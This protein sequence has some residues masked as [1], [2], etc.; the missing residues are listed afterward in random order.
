MKWPEE[1]VLVRHD[2]SRFNVLKEIKAAD[3]LYQE[4][5]I[6][7]ESDPDSEET[8]K[9]ARMV[10]KVFSLGVSD[11]ET[12]LLHEESPLAETVGRKLRI[13][14]GKSVPDIIFVSP[15]K[16]TRFTLAGLIRGWPELNDVKIFE[17]ERIREQEHGI[18]TLFNDWRVF[19]T[20][21]PEQR[22][23]AEMQGSYWYRYPQGESVPDVR[24]R[25]R[26]WVSTVVRDFAGKKVLAVTHHL[27]ILAIRANLER[28][29][30]EQ[31]IEVD[32]HD[33]PHNCS[34]TTYRGNPNKGSNGKL[35]LV[36]YN[37]V[38]Y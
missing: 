34:V 36:Q 1:L 20:L 14:H 27:C 29:S 10:A 31:F 8:V 11:P 32:K 16:R 37:Q 33:K 13:I 38:L 18:A 26:S 9:L 6:A 4:F 25:V 5:R 24:E 23:F 15:Y 35:E 7:F 21:Y 12:L 30:A 2:V 3:P 28:M 22:K 17:D 19:Y